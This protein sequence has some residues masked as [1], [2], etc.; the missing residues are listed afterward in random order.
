MRG[1]SVGL[2]CVLALCAAAFAPLCAAQIKVKV[3]GCKS[4][5]EISA[6]DAPLSQVLARLADTLKFQLHLE[7]AADAPVNVHMTARPPELIAAL[8]GKERV[9]I[10]QA[11]DPRCPGQSRVARVWLLPKGEASAQ[12]SGNAFRTPANQ[13]ATR[14]QLRAQEEHSRRLKEEYDA[15]VKVYGKPPPGV[16]QEEAK[17]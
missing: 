17:P 12:T 3:L 11:A 5:V 1:R 13:T 16:E 8:A 9:M 15:H 10:S 7:A 4:G 2:P 6:R 14:D